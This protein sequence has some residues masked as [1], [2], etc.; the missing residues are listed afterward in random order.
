MHDVKKMI[1][2]VTEGTDPKDVLR[3][4]NED[5][6]KEQMD[7][8]AAEFGM[9]Y[10]GQQDNA[11]G[12]YWVYSTAG[13]PDGTSMK[14]MSRVMQFSILRANQWKQIRDMGAD[15]EIHVPVAVE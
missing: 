15:Q 14:F 8:V 3:Q 1:Q 10:K 9:T 2:E 4:V 5:S 13:T 12:P 11:G 6:S 7:D